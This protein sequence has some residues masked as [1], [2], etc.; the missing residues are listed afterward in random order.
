LDE[1]IRGDVDLFLEWCELEQ[2]LLRDIYDARSVLGFGE[3]DQPPRLDEEDR[4]L[5]PYSPT[6]PSNDVWHVAMRPAIQ[7]G[8][9]VRSNTPIS[10]QFHCE[11]CCS[12]EN[13]DECYVDDSDDVLDLECLSSTVLRVPPAVQTDV[14]V[15]SEE[16]TDVESIIDQ[17]GFGPVKDIEDSKDLGSLGDPSPS[18]SSSNGN[19]VP[20]LHSAD[21]TVVDDSHRC[22]LPIVGGGTR[23]P[24]PVLGVQHVDDI[25]T[26][27]VSDFL[28]DPISRH[29]LGLSE[30]KPTFLRSIYTAIQDIMIGAAMY[31]LL[32]VSESDLTGLWLCFWGWCSLSLMKWCALGTHFQRRWVRPTRAILIDWGRDCWAYL[33]AGFFNCVW[34]VSLWREWPSE[35]YILIVTPLAL[36]I[37]W[38]FMKTRPR[39]VDQSGF[40]ERENHVRRMHL[41]QIILAILSLVSGVGFMLFNQ[42]QP[43]FRVTGHIL[44]LLNPAT[45]CVNQ[46]AKGCA[47]RY[48]PH[49][50][51]NSCTEAE[52][53]SAVSNSLPQDTEVKLNRASLL[54]AYM[55]ENDGRIPDWFEKLS[56]FNKELI[57]SNLHI[58][59]KDFESG[60]YAFEI[61]GGRVCLAVPKN[62]DWTFEG[63][64]AQYVRTPDGLHKMDHVDKDLKPHKLHSTSARVRSDSPDWRK[65]VVFKSGGFRS[66]ANSSQE[67]K[68]AV[69]QE[70]EGI[71]N[72][73]KDAKKVKG[74]LEEKESADGYLITVEAGTNIVLSEQ[75]WWHKY[76]PKFLHNKID[77]LLIVLV[78]ALIA[79]FIYVFNVNRD[80]DPVE[81]IETVG[82][83]T[84][85]KVVNEATPKTESPPQAEATK[86]EPEVARLVESLVTK[87]ELSTSK[88]K[89]SPVTIDES[90]DVRMSEMYVFDDEMDRQSN[91]RKANTARADVKS[92]V[93][94]LRDDDD[95]TKVRVKKTVERN[96]SRK[97]RAD[98][99]RNGDGEGPQIQNS[100]YVFYQQDDIIKHLERH[101][102]E[103]MFK[104]IV[105]YNKQTKQRR[106]VKT[107]EELEAAKAEGFQIAPW[108]LPEEAT[109]LKV[110][111]EKFD[112]KFPPVVV[113]ILAKLGYL[114]RLED[115]VDN[116]RVWSNAAQNVI[117]S[118]EELLAVDSVREKLPG[119][120]DEDKM[121]HQMIKRSSRYWNDDGVSPRHDFG[122][123]YQ[124]T[125]TKAAVVHSVRHPSEINRAL[126]SLKVKGA[127]KAASNAPKIQGESKTN[128]TCTLGTSGFCKSEYC[129]LDHSNECVND[130]GVWR[131]ITLVL[132]RPANVPAAEPPSPRKPKV[133]VQK[134][135]AGIDPAVLRSLVDEASSSTI[136]SDKCPYD[137]C[138]ITNCIKQHKIVAVADEKGEH[139]KV[140]DVPKSEVESQIAVLNE[141]NIS[142]NTDH[143][144]T[145]GVFTLYCK[146]GLTPDR[147][148]DAIGQ[149]WMGPHRLETVAHNFWDANGVSRALDFSDYYI[150]GPDRAM[151]YAIP[152]SVKRYK[153]Q[154]T[155]LVDDYACFEVDAVLMK[156]LHGEVRYSLAIPK[157]GSKYAMV[158]A[159]P[160]RGVLTL[161]VEIDKMDNKGLLRYSTDTEPGY[162]GAPIIDRSSGKV[163][164]RHKGAIPNSKYNCA[165]GHNTPMIAMCGTVSAHLGVIL[166]KN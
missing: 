11:S 35:Y 79:V 36:Y 145:N 117:L 99:Y 132:P 47:T 148:N 112:G 92:G 133:K 157:Q 9:L 62:S 5:L 68:S 100:N 66:R 45:G 161:P 41:L 123:D 121:L 162:S 147:R 43:A 15:G 152:A 107:K 67:E 39:I 85:K 138:T 142:G 118:K 159:H 3:D 104:G 106:N 61:N 149:C 18:R 103:P 58:T 59:L 19:V 22:D 83:T 101:S 10:R 53:T 81:V 97:D 75:V 126:E 73:V 70:I 54:L 80:T 29:I 91:K 124:F 143:T 87:I 163:V 31:C 6:V 89:V 151:H 40:W 16:N 52:V 24:P 4:M 2:Q 14:D 17:I 155:D 93:N 115:K 42:V 140:L 114:V 120:S 102:D 125:N 164:G 150:L 27:R 94:L 74:G 131:K 49:M 76:V 32:V 28:N 105:M 109:Y 21:V 84:P 98:K 46:K 30:L 77:H 23:V 113:S 119:A 57:L 129:R 37:A 8:S 55:I 146:R 153:L 20:S 88:E 116:P 128:S 158:V 111:L 13:C 44:G 130:N 12:D 1:S 33:R 95:K 122:V 25:E 63:V 64:R 156:E 141:S 154:N 144:R 34:V 50:K 82:E 134:K 137:P 160:S 51:C 7:G 96:V 90:G 60:H 166:P 56:E 78:M 127:A 69:I 26:S 165:I 139:G 38:Y 65:P 86:V 110:P 71:I 72:Q 136:R 135:Q 108:L 48:D